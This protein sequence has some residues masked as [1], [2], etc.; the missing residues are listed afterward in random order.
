M[1]MERPVDEQ[2]AMHPHGVYGGPIVDAHVHFWDPGQLRYPWLCG[3]PALRRAF[4]P[5]E[6]AAAAGASAAARCV[7]VEGNC[8][9]D[10]AA[11]EVA[12]LER[13][14]REDPR[15]AG[16]VAFADLTRPGALE[17]TLA[18]LTSVPRVKGVRQN[19]QGH[20]AGFAVQR[21]FVDGARTV[22]RVGLTFDLCASHGQLEETDALVA[23]CPDTLFV[24]DHCGKPPIRSGALDPWRR[25][26]ARLAAHPNVCCKLSGL[27]TEADAAR[28]RE[29]QLLPYAAYV[30]ECFGVDRVLY[31]SDWPVLTLAGDYTRWHRFTALLTG[32]WTDDERHRFYAGNAIRVYQL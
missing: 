21:A 30:I 29:E 13:L 18:C 3:I 24:L 5:A 28:W 26:I 14:G 25:D 22:G 19:I 6:Y 15:I 7:V 17:G 32:A 23:Q 8:H 4:L 11:R 10:D 9:P 16:I 31:G 12:L 2:V 20:P 1:T 27:L